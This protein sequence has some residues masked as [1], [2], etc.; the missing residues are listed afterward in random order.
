ML[1]AGALIHRPH[2]GESSVDLIEVVGRIHGR[3]RESSRLP[4]ASPYPLGDACVAV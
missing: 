2:N 4:L 1:V 3:L